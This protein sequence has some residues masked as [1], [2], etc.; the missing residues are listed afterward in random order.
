MHVVR[1]TIYFDFFELLQCIDFLKQRF[2]A[3]VFIILIFE[4]FGL[5]WV[6]LILSE[7]TNIVHFILVEHTE[8]EVS[9]LKFLQILL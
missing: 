8:I 6:K 5:K 7:E 1:K 4:E 3:Y 2:D 9:F